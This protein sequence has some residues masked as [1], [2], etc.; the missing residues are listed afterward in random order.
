MEDYKALKQELRTEILAQIRAEVTAQVRAEVAAMLTKINKKLDETH[1][2]MKREANNAI[3]AQSSEIIAVRG[4]IERAIV[5]KL[6]KKYG[7]QISSAIE[8]YQY[9]NFDADD[10]INKYRH[11]VVRDEA[12]RD[13]KLLTGKGNNKHVITEHM[14]LVFDYGED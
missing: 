9:Q 10:M 11:Q 5:D 2:T 3:V 1:E 6:D 8:M 4:D 13:Q 14:S 12:K 7:H